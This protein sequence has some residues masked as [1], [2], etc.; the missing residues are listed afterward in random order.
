MRR[1][2]RLRVWGYTLAGGGLVCILICCA[3][4]IQQAVSLA[5][6][7]DE[8]N[9]Q[10]LERIPCH[11]VS[12]QTDAQSAARNCDLSAIENDEAFEAA[13]Y[14]LDR[15]VNFYILSDASWPEFPLNRVDLE[16][17]RK[18]RV[19]QSESF[20]TGD[21]WRIYSR[22]ATQAGTS[23]EIMV[24]VMEAASW[25]LLDTAPTARIDELLRTEAQRVALRLG[26]DRITSSA[27]AWQ[28]VDATT[29]RVRAWSGNVPT[30]YPKDMNLKHRELYYRDG[31]VGLVRTT[32][33]G[34]LTAVSLDAISSISALVLLAMAAFLAGTLASY[35]L[36]RRLVRT[37]IRRPISLD[38]ALKVGESD[39][40]EFKEEGDHKDGLLR[41]VSA[42]AN[43][44]GGTLFVGVVDKTLEVVG[45][46]GASVDKRDAYDRG[47]R[48]SIRQRVQPPPD[49]MIDYPSWN[50]RVVVRIFVP[51]GAARHSFDGRYYKREGTQTRFVVNGEIDRL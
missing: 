27:D 18:F 32:N 38:D 10:T 17:V 28:V 33:S 42:F 50:D 7:L 12:T 31:K 26:K 41:E 34:D 30:F 19:P 22:T 25:S 24:A 13:D 36:A 37:G 1:T 15:R 8:R 48:D 51:A 45:V 2:V 20:E 49:V 46:R 47:L 3:T 21:R 6:E 29:G 14:V 39:V 23:Y 44:N 35:P 9:Q 16:F 5:G 4:V 40:V 43:T 11:A